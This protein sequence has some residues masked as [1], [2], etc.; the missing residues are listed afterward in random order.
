MDLAPFIANEALVRF[1]RR[2]EVRR[3]WPNKPNQFYAAD[4]FRPLKQRSSANFR[5][6]KTKLSEFV[7]TLIEEPMPPGSSGFDTISRIDIMGRGMRGQ[8]FLAFAVF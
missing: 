4:F 1:S 3:F 5:F 7:M 8:T 6:L 2:E